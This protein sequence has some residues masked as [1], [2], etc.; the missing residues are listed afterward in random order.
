M[1]NRT[2]AEGR[3]QNQRG[4]FRIDD[5]VLLQYEEVASAQVPRDSPAPIRG[6]AAFL[7]CARLAENRR[8]L[9]SSLRD[10]Q[11]ESSSIVRH[12]RLLDE[13]IEILANALLVTEMETM[14][15]SRQRVEL[16]ATGIA[17]HTERQLSERSLLVLR[18][19][20]LPSFTGVISNG[21]V[22]RSTRFIGSGQHR[23]LTTLEFV[24]MREST[25]DLIAKHILERQKDKVRG[26]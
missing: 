22:V 15:T 4:A 9:H 23:F 14:D 16:S 7:F 26:G 8:R 24:N 19:V 6:S 2:E 21:R 25:R 17:F 13:R 18:L 12:L 1:R 10:V 11:R 5:E 20:L 3:V